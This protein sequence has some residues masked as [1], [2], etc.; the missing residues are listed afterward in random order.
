[1]FI[2]IFISFYFIFIKNFIFN[3]DI[4]AIRSEKKEKFYIFILWIGTSVT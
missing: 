2:L 3:T 1:M 4:P